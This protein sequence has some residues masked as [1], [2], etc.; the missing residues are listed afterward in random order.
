MKRS[1]KILSVILVVFIL[2]SLMGCSRKDNDDSNAQ[3]AIKKFVNA[4]YTIDKTDIERYKEIVFPGKS[5]SMK[6]QIS[7]YQRSTEEFKS[8]L[9]D[10]AYQ[11]L[12]I[13]RMSY[14]RV[15]EAYKGKYYVT[16][17][18]IKLEKQS[19]DEKLQTIGYYY[20]LELI[21]KTILGNKTKTLKDRGEIEAVK[22][23]N[24]WKVF[25]DFGTI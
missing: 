2:L 8:L 10:K 3:N 17:K 24:T 1:A 12:T 22:V 13:N 20:N 9:T 11:N 19:K 16:V 5:E 23:K 21:Q 7:S 15:K 18:S 14:G 6:K 4:Y 25:I